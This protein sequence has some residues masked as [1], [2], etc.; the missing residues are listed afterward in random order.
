ML[1][2]AG[3]APQAMLPLGVTSGEAVGFSDYPDLMARVPPPRDGTVRGTDGVDQITGIKVDEIILALAGGDAVWAG[4]GD[5]QIQG[6]R[7]NDRLYGEA[8]AD[9]LVGGAGKDRQYGGVDNLS[10][11]FVFTARSQSA[12]GA[13]RD[14]VFD[15]TS[16]VDDLDLR[17]ID[18]KP[19]TVGDDAFA[20]A[21]QTAGEYAVWWKATSDGVL[22]RAD[23]TGDS[24]ADLEVLL[25]GVTSL[26]SEDVLL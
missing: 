16:G 24:T 1:A 23:V 21:G 22:V 20:W 6:D 9:T 5:D 25:K 17:Q 10:D 8:G 14:L 7:G 26:G 11:H 19:A 2:A 15:F 12:A 13:N 4:R 18:A 3:G